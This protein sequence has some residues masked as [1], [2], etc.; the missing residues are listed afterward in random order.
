MKTVFWLLLLAACTG[1]AHAQTEEYEKFLQKLPSDS[2]VA[3]S[4]VIGY[5]D[6][7]KSFFGKDRDSVIAKSNEFKIFEKSF[8]GGYKRPDTRPYLNR[9]LYLGVTEIGESHSKDAN[10]VIGFAQCVAGKPHIFY[11]VRSD[12]RICSEAFVFFRE[13][14]YAHFKLGHS[15]CGAE[16]DVVDSHKKELAADL[17]A[18]KTILGF[19]DGYRIIDYI[20]ATFSTM[21]LPASR[22]HPGSQ[23]RILNLFM[24]LNS[25]VLNLK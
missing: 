8:G 22:W 20:V 7:W 13:H 25:E 4:T 2:L 24:Q 23:D 14:E 18:A 19:E 6:F 17:E 5:N 21:N 15:G 12:P 10:G 16:S 1:K 3:D 11:A 9:K